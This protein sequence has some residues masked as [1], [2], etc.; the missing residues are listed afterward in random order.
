LTELTS[1]RYD[2]EPRSKFRT[3]DLAAAMLTHQ[4]WPAF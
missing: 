4:D 2:V 1:R 3:V